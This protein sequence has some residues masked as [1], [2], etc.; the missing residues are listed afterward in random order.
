MKLGKLEVNSHGWYWDHRRLNHPA[1]MVWN[2][3]M[4][5]MY[6][7]GLVLFCALAALITMDPAEAKRIW[8]ENRVSF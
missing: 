7:V 4:L 2:V 5:P 6:L 3:L 8:T 1:R